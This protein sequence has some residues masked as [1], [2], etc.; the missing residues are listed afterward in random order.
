MYMYERHI[1]CLQPR[2]L[3]AG[4]RVLTCGEEQVAKLSDKL[5][6]RDHAE[7][8]RMVIK[9]IFPICLCDTR[10]HPPFSCISADSFISGFFLLQLDSL[11]D[12]YAIAKRARYPCI[13]KAAQGETK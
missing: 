5:L 8:I 7:Q 6:L 11:P 1:L 10:R 3:A 2:L 4:W 13:L 9:P 12:H